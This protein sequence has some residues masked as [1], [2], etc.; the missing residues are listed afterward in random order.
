MSGLVRGANA[1]TVKCSGE[2]EGPLGSS[3]IQFIHYALGI[4]VWAII[5]GQS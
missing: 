5:V 3:L 1:H 4:L 2:E